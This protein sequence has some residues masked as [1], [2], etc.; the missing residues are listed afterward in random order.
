MISFSDS[1]PAMCGFLGNELA[2]VPFEKL[3]AD[4]LAKDQP[5]GQNEQ[6]GDDRRAPRLAEPIPLRGDWDHVARMILV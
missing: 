5:D 3:V 6:A 2:V 4:R 1:P